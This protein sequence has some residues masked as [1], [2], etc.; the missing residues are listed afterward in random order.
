MTQSNVETRQPQILSHSRLSCWRAC[1]RRHYLA[2]ELALRPREVSF[3][4]RVGAAFHAAHEAIDTGADVGAVIEREVDDPYDRALVAAMLDGHLR[5]W[6]GQ[7]NEVVA[8]EMAFDLPLTNPTTGAATPVWRLAGKVDRIERLP[9]GRLALR[10]RKTTSKDFAPGSDYWVQLYMDQQISLY[11][12]A[13][14]ALGYDVQTILYDVTRRPALR[15]LKATPEEARKYVKSTGALY[16]NQ[17]AEDETPEEFA[18][19]IAE[20]IASKPEHYFARIEIPRL[21]QDLEDCAAEVW[22]QQQSLRAMQRGGGWYR[23]PNSCFEPYRC[24]YVDIC[25][26]RDLEHVTPEGFVRVEDVHPELS[27]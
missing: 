4:L 3:P 23:S 9:D 25:Q 13:A 2:Y 24:D 7:D 10:E 27:A 20:N 1:P 21:E 15:P 19:R 17:R 11:V 26:N 16:A 8:T 6:A 14:R 18:G 5:R 12:I 22:M